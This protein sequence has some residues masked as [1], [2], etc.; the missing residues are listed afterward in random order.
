MARPDSQGATRR[1]HRESDS[2][3]LV[4]PLVSET[5]TILATQVTLFWRCQLAQTLP[6]LLLQALVSHTHGQPAHRGHLQQ[7]TAPTP[8]PATTGKPS[9]KKTRQNVNPCIDKT[10]RVARHLFRSAFGFRKGAPTEGA[11]RTRWQEFPFWKTLHLPKSFL[12]AL[13]LAFCT[14][15][16][17]PA[18]ATTVVEF[19]NTNLD[20]YFITA[21]ANEAAQID[22]GSAGPGWI[23]TGYTFNS[24]GSTSVCRF[25]GSQSPGPNSHFYTVGVDECLGLGQQ[26]ATT[27]ATEKRWNFESFD[28]T[29]TAPTN[30]T[31]PASTV[32]VYRAYNNG[33]SRGVDSNHRITTSLTALQE[34][35]ARGW[36][37][38]GVVMCAPTTAG[39]NQIIISGQVMKGPISLAKI[40]C[41]IGN[42]TNGMPKPSMIPRVSDDQGPVVPVMNG[43]Y[44]CPVPADTKIVVPNVI[45]TPISIM[46]EEATGKNVSLEPLAK[47]A[48]FFK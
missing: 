5:G 9:D 26:Q 47:V 39:A 46:K 11:I 12:P 18:L 37:N 25:Y 3:S 35:V 40:K 19:Y 7:R 48:T 27:P 44:S 24:G 34:V 10:A 42:L 6:A 23:R 22:G 1:C 29:S 41:F 20:N 45:Q 2:L 14:V 21:D 15:V 28:F 8:A 17:T 30:G 32:P 43:G 31:C 13:L 4:N 33:F 16:T 36:I 38:E